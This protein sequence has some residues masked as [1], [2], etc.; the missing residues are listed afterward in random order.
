MSTNPKLLIVDDEEELSE[1]MHII[2][3][4]E[5][6][7]I[8][9]AYTLEEGKIKWLRELPPIVLLDNYLPDGFGIDLIEKDRSLLDNCKV[10]MVTADE[11]PETRRRAK[12][13]GIHYFIQKPF[14]LK[15]IRELI[16]QVIV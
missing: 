16:Q 8:E 9:C 15:L 11:L 10:I 12:S 4:D 1:L 6:Y 14:S 13:L 3:K 5:E 2:L 7:K